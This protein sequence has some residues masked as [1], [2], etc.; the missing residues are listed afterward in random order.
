MVWKKQSKDF[1]GGL[2]KL[3]VEF[4]IV[5]LLVSQHALA[6]Q[7][8][9]YEGA[10]SVLLPCRVSF[11]LEDT[12][13]LWHCD[14]LYPEIVHSWRDERDELT[15]Q[16]QRFRGRTSMASDGA[17]SGDLSLTL[18]QPHLSDSGNYTCLIRKQSSEL[19]LTLIQLR[20]KVSP[21]EVK[22]QEGSEFIQL[23]CQIPPPL[24]E[25]A[26]VEWSRSEPKPIIVH[27]YP[28][29]SNLL[30][31]EFFCGRTHMNKDL[32][33]TGDLSLTL[34]YPTDRDSGTYTCT[35]HRDGDVLRQKVVLHHVREKF[36]VWAKVLLALLAVGLV[37]G[38]GLAIYFWNYFK[39]ISRMEVVEVV[40]GSK[41]VQLP[42][43]A[44]TTL[45]EDASVEWRLSGLMLKPTI[46]HVCKGGGD[47]ADTQNAEYK[48]RTEMV[49]DLTDGDLSLTLSQPTDR[50][51]GT[52]TSTVKDR[53]GRILE[54]KQLTLKVKVPQVKA[55]EGVESVVLPCKDMFRPS[56]DDTVEWSRPEPWPMTVHMYQNSADYHEKQ[57]WIYRSRTEMKTDQVMNRDLSL[58]LKNP[59][60]FDSG[61]YTCTVSRDGKVLKKRNVQLLVTET[62][63]SSLLTDH[64]E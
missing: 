47:Q 9:V 32:L 28:N 44:T 37:A 1:V 14:D 62:D 11:F 31:E 22:V 2:L 7:V 46:V 23:P 43:K 5:V 35:A 64:Q 20:V 40:F 45:P 3:S 17:E 36:S 59:M 51:S 38:G 53:D 33:K 52:Y 6:L 16:D 10:E 25:D 50:D 54:K 12:T 27:V 4:V 56:A 19:T 34:K 41:S 55:E 57:N 60:A 48:G 8:E 21:V 30:L 63:S 18:R 61:S 49:K 26:R 13:V 39:T 42:F 29:S 15:G 24:P 58:T